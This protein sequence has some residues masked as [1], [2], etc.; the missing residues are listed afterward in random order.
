MHVL[1]SL[2]KLLLLYMNTNILT[3]YL[4]TFQYLL[5]I[6]NEVFMQ[7]DEIVLYNVAV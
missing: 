3:I 1:M 4:S 6:R 2:Y 7:Q 5:A